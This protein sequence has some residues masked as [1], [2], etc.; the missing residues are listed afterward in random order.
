MGSMKRETER[1]RNKSSGD[2][3]RVYFEVEIEGQ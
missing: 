2:C 1:K 3:V